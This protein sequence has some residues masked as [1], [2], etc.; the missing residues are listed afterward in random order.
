[1]KYYIVTILIAVIIFIG[2][3]Y[4]MNRLSVAPSM[5]IQSHTVIYSCDG[6][7]TIEAIFSTN[8]ATPSQKEDDRPVPNGSVKL[9]LSDGRTMI[10]AQTVSGSGAQYVSPDESFVF[11]SKGN[12]ALVLENSEEKG[13]SG[14]IAV[15]PEPVGK[16][17]SYIYSNDT[18]SF[19][20]RLPQGYSI[21]EL[22]RYQM[23]PDVV[24][25]GVQFKIPASLAQGTNL[26]NDTYISIERVPQTQNCAASI[27]LDG[28]H[29]T[30]ERI[31]NGTTYS[32]IEASNAGAG[33]RYEESIYA[34]PGTN[35]C[36]AV[37]YFVHYG[38]IQNYEPGAVKEFDKRA[39][40]EQFDLIRST[41]VVN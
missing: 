28:T 33:N 7:K 36:V 34:I 8:E 32:F 4:A 20:I 13:Y 6:Q 21:D 14:C 29:P 41:L 27:F 12:G 5:N 23:S 37:R 22:Y 17:L 39:L 31:E 1:M 15:A 3:W 24:I 10:L 2:G 19:S 25:G 9:V 26:F 38:A 18:N 35:P 16:N 30:T 40:L 11:W